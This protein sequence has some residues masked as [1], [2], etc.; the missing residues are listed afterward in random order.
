MEPGRLVLLCLTAWAIPGAGHFWLGKRQKAMVFL[1]A[2]PMMFA[3]GLALK[4]PLHPFTLAE[5][6]VFLQACANLSMGIPYFLASA[7]GFGLGQIR[8]VTYEYGNAFL[9]VSGLLNLIV[10]IDVY[11]VAK[12]RK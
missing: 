8:A 6:I 3:I 11:D 9:V 12:G 10:V 7:L 1:L 2:L 5:P 4:G